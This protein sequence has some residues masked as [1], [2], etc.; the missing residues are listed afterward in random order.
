LAGYNLTLDA[1]HLVVGRQYR[2]CVDVDGPETTISFGDTQLMI[3]VSPISVSSVKTVNIAANQVLKLT[4][5]SRCSQESRGYVSKDAC[6]F[7]NNNGVKAAVANS[8]T[9]AVSY[10]QHQICQMSST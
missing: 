8:N 1:D 5:S 9:V 2:F 7:T 10:F 6:E 4:C 3:Y